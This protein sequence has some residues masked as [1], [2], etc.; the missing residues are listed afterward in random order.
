MPRLLVAHQT[1]GIETRERRVIDS[2]A[3]WETTWR[4]IFQDQQPAPS[5]PAIDFG[6]DLVVL[7]AMGTQSSGGFSITIEGV[8]RTADRLFVV[9][10]ESSPGENCLSTAALTAP[11]AAVRVQRTGLPV[12]FIERKATKSC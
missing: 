6:S 10:R 12:D 7:A 3:D 9:V 8:Y 11:V 2:A 4:R 5:V 1:S